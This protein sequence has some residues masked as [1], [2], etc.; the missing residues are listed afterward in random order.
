M[1]FIPPPLFK[2]PSADPLIVFANEPDVP[3]EEIGEFQ[4]AEYIV[5]LLAL[6]TYMRYAEES[7][8]VDDVEDELIKRGL[9][10]LRAADA[11][12]DALS[13]FLDGHLSTNAQ[14]TMLRRALALKAYT[15]QGA[16]RRALQFRTLLSRGGPATMKGIF[17]N[18]KYVRQVREAISAA[19][20]DD[21]DRAL[22]V[23]AAMPMRNARFRSWIDQASEQAGSGDGAPQP[24]D[25]ASSSG[26]DETDAIVYQNIQQLAA[27]GAEE[28]QQA[29]EARAATLDQVE[30][31]ATEA[32]RVSLKV[33]QM[34]DEPPIRSEVVGLATAAVVAALSDPTRL[35]NVPAPLRELDDE[36][37][38]A[39]LTEGR[40]LV[41]A[42][43]GAG[44]SKTLVSRIDYLV[45]VRK[46]NPSRIMAC[47]FNRKAATE[48]K[49]KIAGV[50]GKGSVMGTS[51]VQVGTMHSLFAKLIVGSRDTPGFGTPEEQAMLRAPRLI[52][53]PQKGEKSVSPA[54]L[55]I[56]IRG[57]WEDCSPEQLVER[58]GFKL[59]WI[60]SAPK[61]KKANLLL[62]KWRGND[63][64]LQEA[65]NSVTSQSEAQAA[66]WYDMYLGL[67][68]DI[69][70]WRPPCPS[71]AYDSFMSRNRKGGERLGDLDDMLK[72][73][74][75][76]LIRD[77]KAKKAIQGMFD[78]ILVDECQ[79]L[80]TIQHQIFALMSEHINPD[81]KDRSIFLIGDDKQCVAASTPVATHELLY[82]K[83]G[84]L[85]EGDQVLSYRNGSVVK[86]LV[87]HVKPSSWSWGYK[88]TTESGRSLTMSP[89][90]KIWAQGP[91]LEE[92]Q[93][94][95]YLMF[96]KDLGF[97]VGI[98]NK[99]RDEEYLNSF[100][101]RAFMEKAERM[102]VLEVCADREAA[103]LAEVGYSLKYGV[104]TMVFGG[105]NRGI[106]QERVNA[107]FKEFGRNGMRILEAK[108]LS[109]DL[110]HWMS[111]SYTKHGRD[112][113][114][115]QMIAHGSSG[116]QVTLEWSGDDL[117]DRLDGVRFIKN[118]EG[119]RRVRKWFSNY[120][121]ALVFA[122]RLA[123]LTGANLSRRLSTEEGALRLLNAAGIF[124][125]MEV[126]VYDPEGVLLEAVS[127][128][129]KV[130]GIEF[131]DLDVDDASN[132][133]GDGI[134]SHNSI[135][136]FRGAKPE[137]F[138]GLFDNPDW[139]TRMIRTNYRC[140]PE[141]VEAANN[142]IAV[143][144]DRIPME[145]RADPR[146]DRGRASIQ[147]STP[148]TNVDAAI[149]TIGRYRK[150]I[151]EGA[152]P[153]DFAVLA[154]TNA[155]LNDFE[156]ACIINEIPYLRR[157]GRGFLEAPESRAVIG[158]LDLAAGNDYEK[159]KKSLV[160]VLMKP[161]RSL[162]IG[163][164]DVER[165]VNEALDD[166]ARR[167]RVDIKSVRP[168]VLLETRY[169]NL[170]A[171]KLKQPYR[172][173]I[174]NSAGDSSKGEW[175]YKK[176]VEELAQNLKGLSENIRDLRDYVEEDHTTP[177]LLGYV[178]DNMKSRVTGWDK[179][180]R[181]EVTTTVTL[182]EQI[183]S[184][185]AVFSDDDDDGE[186]EKETPP[187]EVNEEGLL[188][189]KSPEEL[190]KEERKGL[191]AVQFL[192][193]LAQPNSNDQENLTDPTVA[194][195]FVRKLDRYSKI[196]ETL[197]IDPVKWEKEQSK[198][199]DEGKRKAK[200][201]AITL[202]TVH[203]SPADEPVLTLDG[204]VPI[205]QLDPNKHRLASFIKNCNQLVWGRQNTGYQFVVARQPYFGDLLTLKTERSQ[206]RVTPDHKIMVRFT[207]SFMRKHVVYLMRRGDWW[208]VGI[209]VS[210]HRPYKS[211]G[212]AGRMA[213]EKADEGWILG[214]YG[215]R[216][217]ASIAEATIQAQWG[218]PGLT[219]EIAKGREIALPDLHA[220][221][222]SL[223]HIVV[224]RAV[225]LLESYGLSA[226][227]PLY[228]RGAGV[229]NSF[230]KGFLIEARNV[231]SGYMAIPVVNDRF[232]NRVG[233]HN[234][235]FRPDWLPVYVTKAPY[236]GDVYS[237][238]VLPHSTYI[239]GGAAVGNS[240]KGA[241]W[242][243]VA[244]M[245][246][247]GIFPFEPKRKPDEPPPDPIEEEARMKAER[248]LAYVALTRAAVNLEI[249]CPLQ[250]G[251]S[252]FVFQAGLQVGENVPKPGMDSQETVKEAAAD[253]WYS[254]GSN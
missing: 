106:N 185:V 9:R 104:P 174:I 113:R 4:V 181:R 105:E 209:C 35:Q 47:S 193:A 244:V 97:R 169:L 196:A 154:R 26:S 37:R 172:L 221:H 231:L 152:E 210:A 54:S 175:M 48:L 230:N 78:H 122:E 30:R 2:L 89:N 118:T 219:F 14:K 240:V 159:M 229:R 52:A 168:D 163:P 142:L 58:Y 16:S 102:W 136:Q 178:L 176:R 85:K 1:A 117:D 75:D 51:G 228:R 95:V 6:D 131:V 248:N 82:K 237:L 243:T 177:E 108:H 245:M 223:K 27:S 213:T 91:N 70:G 96:R 68:G 179:D 43:A 234:E 147:V 115:I 146:K 251:M 180:S 40:V 190:E 167:E 123:G 232:T 199:A 239:S 156:T 214:V 183:T 141:I 143:D 46:V 21:A 20:L 158:Y 74:R 116:S 92:G 124:S 120:R 44:K 81:S 128:V 132:F 13:G 249:S 220:I 41:A 161:D 18:Q 31:D 144:T 215:S 191:G 59:N 241:E 12:I 93:M 45:C 211:A 165:A 153:E 134:L 109:F 84:E 227:V 10:L 80:N 42:G 238:R 38:A 67:K 192:Y 254:P 235:R 114:T 200:P 135:Y 253:K 126:V 83:A 138:K 151:D 32:A 236:S 186:G 25:A 8:G 71:K 73:L 34:P 173:K 195:G 72:I 133:F 62:N 88:I 140:Q 224:D 222:D 202:S 39:A 166:V 107:I 94:A 86:Q 15:T 187:G 69:P 188:P 145:A 184:D 66:V 162:F 5:Y 119:R 111:R 207:E 150:D 63:I 7:S 112:R 129:V 29:Q 49:E 11:Q 130:E 60:E 23:F 204:W 103:L 3:E 53:P 157:G 50:L 98:T 205:G 79:D 217:E 149:D 87:R 65:R 121:E 212:V 22:D 189:T 247:K 218:I 137:L 250:N 160:A 24:I 170:L 99:C 206:T 28:A 100:G 77:P 55:S 33:N 155:E 101:G 64:G 76:I 57:L 225:K 56:A 216:L 164:E 246:P 182:R 203:C 110:P 208:R 148:E 198:I 127:S 226:Q 61:A 171:D 194:K 201:P 36:Q 90:H 233:K 139:T 252:P 125:G 17:E 19:M 242:N 197:R